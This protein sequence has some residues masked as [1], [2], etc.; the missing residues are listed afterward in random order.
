MAPPKSSRQ[1][2]EE[3]G[4]GIQLPRLVRRTE[5][6]ASD[7]E[8]DV[9]PPHL[10][11][12]P[13]YSNVMFESGRGPYEVTKLDPTFS[14]CVQEFGRYE[15]GLIALTMAVPAYIGYAKSR[16]PSL[17]QKHVESPGPPRSFYVLFGLST[18]LIAGIGYAY[19]Y[20][21]CTFS[22]CDLIFAQPGWLGSCRKIH[23]S[24]IQLRFVNVSVA[25]A[26]YFLL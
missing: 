15:L 26:G 18:G 8:N 23:E 20:S 5:M 19:A 10:C 11:R 16:T 22:H 21:Y 4:G 24:L 2:D 17:T 3:T 1:V 9:L 25:P 12:H 6:S 14:E 7:T 13:Y